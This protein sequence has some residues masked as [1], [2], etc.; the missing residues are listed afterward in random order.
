MATIP[1][2]LQP[3]V[4]RILHKVHQ[5]WHEKLS[6]RQ[7]KKQPQIGNLVD[8]VFDA[9]DRI[10]EIYALC[11]LGDMRDSTEGNIYIG[12]TTKERAL[13]RWIR[14][15]YA[16]DGADQSHVVTTRLYKKMKL[17]GISKFVIVRLEV[18]YKPKDGLDDNVVILNNAENMWMSRFDSIDSGLNMKHEALRHNSERRGSRSAASRINTRLVR[19][20]HVPLKL[21]LNSRLLPV[22]ASATRQRVYIGRMTEQAAIALRPY[23][24]GHRHHAD[25]QRHLEMMSFE[26]KLDI[27][28]FI[29]GLDDLDPL[30]NELRLVYLMLHEN[31]HDRL[32][33]KVMKFKEEPVVI[34]FPY[35][36]RVMEE[37]NIKVQTLPRLLELQ[38]GIM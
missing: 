34:R 15:T 4:L 38:Q 11:Y 24:W 27:V 10:G 23:T 16:L 1:E 18:I 25:M 28:A 31:L 6:R 32:T 29:H 14:H 30:K 37:M 8:H 33:K 26:K 19:R 13:E 36:G 2:R 9:E 22:G 20:G 5:K 7:K 12:Q 35:L 21:F 17:H 3:P